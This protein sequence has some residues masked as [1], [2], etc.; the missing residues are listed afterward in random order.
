MSH[1]QTLLAW[2]TIVLLLCGFVLVLP[3]QGQDKKSPAPETLLP[4]HSILYVGWDGIDAHQ[5]AWKET[6]AHAAL[7]ESG[8]S[9]LLPKIAAFVGKHAG[10]EPAKILSDSSSHL[11]RKGLFLAVA[12][13]DQGPPIPW[14]TLV[15]PEA[16]GAAPQ[17]SN[18]VQQITGGQTALRTQQVDSRSVV[19]GLLPQTPGIEIGWW[20]EGNHL[21]VAVGMGAVDAALQV[22]AGKSPNLT[23]N[24]V[25]QKY[26]A[27]TAHET[28][29]VA[30]IDLKAVREIVSEIPIPPQS[31]QQQPAKVGDV[32]RTLGLDNVGALACRWGFKNK[33]LWTE[34]TLEAPSPRRGILAF[35]DQKPIAPADLPPLPATTDGFFAWRTDWSKTYDDMLRMA[36]V[37]MKQFGPPDAPPIEA[38]AAQL[39][40]MVGFD[41]RKDLF[42]PLGDVTTVFGDPQQGSFGMGIGVAISVDDA[43]TLR[44][45]LAQLL[46]K[47][48]E[49]GGG[50]VRVKHTEVAGR[51]ISY[52]EFPQF[53]IV[54]PSVV[55]D[56]KWMLISLFPQSATSFVLRTDGRLPTWKPGEDVTA[57][58]KE[59]PAQYTS[60]TVADPRDGVRAAITMAPVMLSFAQMG[61]AQSMRR[62]P[63]DPAIEFPISAADFP[64]AELVTREL[65]TNVAVCSVSDTEI[66]WT[67]RS[68]LPAVP[69]V[70]GAGIGSGAAAT[71]VLV[72]L[73]LPAVQQA[74][75][76]ARRTQSRNN[77]KQLGLA[78]HNYHDTFQAM[79]SGTHLNDRLKPEQRLSWA[80]DIL[81][82]LEQAPLHQQI[83][84]KK[85]WNDAPNKDLMKRRIEVLLNPGV[86]AA[87]NPMFGETHYVGIAG[88]GKDA[89]TLPITSPKAGVFGYNRILRFRDVLD[90]TSNTMAITEAS[91]DYGAWGAGGPS[92]IRS[93]TTKPYING[94]DGIGGPYRGGLNVLFLDGSVRFVSENIDPSVFEA[95]STI[96]GGE[97]IGSF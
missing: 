42:E 53:P 12:T 48:D 18:L 84:L 24:A 94:P 69:L 86:A 93:L 59:M 75:E 56:E 3:G 43:R 30:W 11:A 74:R 38:L 54:N 9:D 36:G 32:L 45:T 81:P 67:S 13:A 27:K 72:A 1:R 21:V 82:Y 89:P 16:A 46:Q 50:D 5:Q 47:V 39:P 33:A 10:P 83:D 71:P 35:A 17:L 57:A 41:P 31:P 40:Q 78:L 70:G 51:K 76:A 64:P 6:A 44:A 87:P 66:R 19:R 29:L 37:F 90:G 91:K 23:T 95:L 73:L 14:V 85:G 62:N 7:V 28:A 58:L 60:L 65:F 55:V 52:L 88:I 68:S 80:V 4:A 8:L 20:A 63:N 77:L 25:F 15:L 49:Q 61:L 97:A 26:R 96:A 2:G 22:A 92:T 34:T 79:H